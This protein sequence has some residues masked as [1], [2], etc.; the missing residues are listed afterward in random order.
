M[1]DGIER[2][3][4]ELRAALDQP[5]RAPRKIERIVR[6]ILGTFWHRRHFF[7]LIHRNEHMADAPAAR[8]WLRRRAQ[9][10]RVIQRTLEE[11]VAQGSFRQMDA[12]IAAEMLLGM[13]RGANRYRTRRDRLESLV[14]A[15]VELFLDGLREDSARPSLARRNPEE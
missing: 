14:A 13:I 3:H 2:L 1:F 12:R 4:T 5:D 7:A 9:I 8:E 15:V 11:G 6:C 10:S